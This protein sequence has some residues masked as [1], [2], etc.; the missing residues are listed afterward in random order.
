MVGSGFGV[1]VLVGP[2]LGE[3]LSLADG[4]ADADGD[5]A[6]ILPSH[7]LNVHGKSLK[8]GWSASLSAAAKNLAHIGAQ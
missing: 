3:A 7:G 2:G 8:L 6:C 1:M 5:M 4:E